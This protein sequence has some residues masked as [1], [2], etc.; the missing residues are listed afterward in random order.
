MS[1]S[2]LIK[3]ISPNLAWRCLIA[4]GI[5]EIIWAYFLKQ[6]EG[7]S[8]IL[9]IVLFTTSLA[10]SM[11]LLAISVKIIPIGLAYPIWTSIGAG[12]SIIIGAVF[13]GK[14]LTFINAIFFVGRVLGL[15][16]FS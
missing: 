6:S 13:F 15:K 4:V 16:N 8:K 5:F 10:V 7:L 1:L 3:E 14:P 9:P 2:Q 12:G 11:I